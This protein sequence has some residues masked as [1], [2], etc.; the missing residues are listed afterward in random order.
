MVLEKECVLK[1]EERYWLEEEK[2][3]EK[4]CRIKRPLLVVFLYK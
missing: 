4:D 1:M 2:E 3:A